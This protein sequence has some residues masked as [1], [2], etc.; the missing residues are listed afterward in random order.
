MQETIDRLRIKIPVDVIAALKERAAHHGITRNAYALVILRQALRERAEFPPGF[1]PP[2]ASPDDLYLST[3]VPARLRRRLIEWSDRQACNL[4]SFCGCLVE[5]FL[6]EHDREPRDLM[7]RHEVE[8]HLERHDSLTREHLRLL[9]VRHSPRFPS[10]VNTAYLSNWLFQRL[11]PQVPHIVDQ[12]EKASLSPRLLAR[13]LESDG[14]SG[15]V[16]D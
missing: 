14:G 9:I 8:L 7:L 4:A 5:R 6:E 10:G 11:R 2:A 16:K 1:E 13:M 12:G 3:E 15:G